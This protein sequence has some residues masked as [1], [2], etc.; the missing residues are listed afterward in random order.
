MMLTIY[1]CAAQYSWTYERACVLFNLAV[2]ESQLANTISRATEAGIR[3]AK[4]AY[5][6]AATIL[7]H[8]RDTLASRLL[9]SL[10]LDLTVQGLTLHISM[11]LAQAQSCVFE[12][13]QT[14]DTKAEL[15]AQIAGHCAD[16]YR[17]AASA[18]P[19]HVSAE[20]DAQCT[21][22]FHSYATM[23]TAT[24]D[25]VSFWNMS[26]KARADADAKG[27]GYG[28]EIAW[29]TVSENACRNAN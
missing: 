24:F 7:A 1:Y 6:L 26:K 22:P 29:L 11:Q 3:D 5:I 4:K 19:S 15:L 21:V 10:P 9:G 16:L 13:A 28:V 27:D 17:A 20:I 18:F 12:M 2:V 23:Y 8:V 25:G 14:K